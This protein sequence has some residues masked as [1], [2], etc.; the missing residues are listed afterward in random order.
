M[1][2]GLLSVL[3]IQRGASLARRS[4]DYLVVDKRDRLSVRV[5]GCLYLGGFCATAHVCCASVLQVRRFELPGLFV[6]DKCAMCF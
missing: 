2:E 4:I 1:S 6:M 3:D 5:E